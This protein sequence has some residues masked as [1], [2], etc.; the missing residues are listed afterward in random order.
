MHVMDGTATPL[1]ILLGAHKYCDHGVLDLH[2]CVWT[3]LQH[4]EGAGFSVYDVLQHAVQPQ[5]QASGY[6]H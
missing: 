1:K 5:H 4:A 2:M 3:E 6:L